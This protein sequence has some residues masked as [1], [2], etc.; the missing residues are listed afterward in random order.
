MPRTTKRASPQERL[1]WAAQKRYSKH[2]SARVRKLLGGVLMILFVVVYALTAM[3]LAQ[4]RVV[5]DSAK[6]VQTCIYAVLG[7]G[8]VLPLLPLIRWMERRP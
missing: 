6:L 5:Q 2:M 1:P 7:L 8:W 3:T 4:A